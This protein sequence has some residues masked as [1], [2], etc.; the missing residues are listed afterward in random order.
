[1]SNA[2]T[3]KDGGKMIN[4]K[5]I[6]KSITALEDV[7]GL[8]SMLEQ[9]TTDPAQKQEFKTMLGDIERHYQYLNT[10]LISFKQAAKN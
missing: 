9:T 10:I 6:L 5:E 1:M 3:Q 4:K 2:G 7:K 8:Y